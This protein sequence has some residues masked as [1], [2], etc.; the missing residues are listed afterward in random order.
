MLLREVVVG[1][2]DLEKFQLD[3]HLLSILRCQHCAGCWGYGIKNDTVLD[4][5]ELI[6]LQERRTDKQAIS[7]E[8]GLPQR[9]REQIFRD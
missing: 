5:E 2:L 4:V 3:G 7:T 9:Y 6:V 1:N 8:E